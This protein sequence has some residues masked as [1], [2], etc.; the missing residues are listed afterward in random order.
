MF[1][2]LS[3]LWQNPKKQSLEQRRVKRQRNKEKG[4]GDSWSHTACQ[5]PGADATHATFLR[6]RLADTGGSSSF[7]PGL[8]EALLLS[9]LQHC[10]LPEEPH[11]LCVSWSLGSGSDQLCLITANYA[12]HCPDTKDVWT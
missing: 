6:V 8:E 11:S 7:L 5:K 1:F 4:K 3:A 9:L 10:S 2:S 12:F